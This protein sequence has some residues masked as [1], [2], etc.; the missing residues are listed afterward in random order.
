M[1]RWKVGAKI[2]AGLGVAV[3]I[4]A[5]FL[6]TNAN[7]VHPTQGHCI[8]FRDKLVCPDSYCEAGFE[9]FTCDTTGKQCYCKTILMQSQENRFCEVAAG[10]GM[11]FE[12]DYSNPSNRPI[13]AF[14][15]YGGMWQAIIDRLVWLVKNETNV[16]EF[17][18]EDYGVK[19]ADDELPMDRIVFTPADSQV[20]EFNLKGY[21]SSNF[22]TL[23]ARA[24][25]EFQIGAEEGDETPMPTIQG[26]NTWE[27]GFL[28]EAPKNSTS[29]FV[30]TTIF[31]IIAPN[32]NRQLCSVWPPIE[33]GGLPFYQKLTPAGFNNLDS[34][35]A[36]NIACVNGLSFLSTL[37]LP[38][39]EK[40]G[41]F[42]WLDYIKTPALNTSRNCTPVEIKKVFFGLFENKEPTP[43]MSILAGNLLVAAGETRTAHE[44]TPKNFLMGQL[45]G[46]GDSKESRK[47]KIDKIREGYCKGLCIGDQSKDY[48]ECLNCSPGSVLD[49]LEE[50][51]DS[52]YTQA[53]YSLL[54]TVTKDANDPKSCGGINPSFGYSDARVSR[55]IQVASPSVEYRGGSMT[56]AE[57]NDRLPNSLINIC[58][59]GNQDA[60][61]GH[62]ERLRCKARAL[63]CYE[64]SLQP[65]LKT[66]DICKV[67]N[68]N[69]A[70]TKWAFCP[71]AITQAQ[72][73][74][75]LQDKSWI[76]KILDIPSRQLRD[77]AI[78]I[79]ENFRDIGNILVVCGFIVIIFS[80]LTGIG[81]TNYQI[82]KA[83]PRIIV[84]VILINVS[85]TVMKLALDVASIIGSGI[86]EIFRSAIQETAKNAQVKFTDVIG[87]ILAGTAGGLLLA[88]G[89][90]AFMIPLLIGALI[91]LVS[92]LLTIALRQVL[93]VVLAIISPVAI[94]SL[95]LPDNK[96]FNRWLSA[97]FGLAFIY[98]LMRLLESGG[99][100]VK[101]IILSDARSYGSPT[102]LVALTL[103]HLSI[104]M[105]PTVIKGVLR[106][107]SSIGAR[108]NDFIS[109]FGQ[110]A[111]DHHQQSYLGQRLKHRRAQKLSHLFSGNIR[112]GR[113]SWLS[114]NVFG[115]VSQSNW[116]N[117]LT[118]GAGKASIRRATGS[119]QQQQNQ[120]RQL[121]GN[122]V[123][124]LNAL[125]K[126]GGTAGSGYASLS[127]DQQARYKLVMS[128]GGSREAILRNLTLIAPTIMAASGVFNIETYRQ[129][130]VQ[131]R[132]LGA[133]N[134]ELVFSIVGGLRVG[135]KKGDSE[136]VGLMQ[137][138]LKAPG[139]RNLAPSSAVTNAMSVLKGSNPNFVHDLM[140]QIDGGVDLQNYS[141]GDP[142]SDARIKRL[143]E[144]KIS[145]RDLASAIIL[146][147]ASSASAD[148]KWI[149]SRLTTMCRQ[150]D[151]S[152]GAGTGQKVGDD[153]KL[154]AVSQQHRDL[155]NQIL[156]L[157]E[158]ASAELPT[159]LALKIDQIAADGT[160]SQKAL[161]E[162][163]S[164]ELLG[165]IINEAKKFLPEGWTEDRD[166]FRILPRGVIEKEV[167]AAVLKADA[168]GLYSEMFNLSRE[169][170]QKLGLTTDSIALP[171]VRRLINNSVKE[172]QKI[173]EIRPTIRNKELG[174]WMSTETLVRLGIAWKHIPVAEQKVIRK[175]VEK[176]IS[177]IIGVQ[178]VGAGETIEDAFAKIGVK[179]ED[180]K[181]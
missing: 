24:S 168:G 156:V 86:P 162:I 123:M 42:N 11:L 39:S 13:T 133:T 16:K 144:M 71:I 18:L 131:A 118:S 139:G 90:L 59:D 54:S 150:L 125:L 157:H 26:D 132:S 153:G 56:E 21:F 126:D 80:Q 69:A 14:Y 5:S 46:E 152:V 146:L 167:E 20:K 112:S 49:L 102:R 85:M 35:E 36:E 164:K 75:Q 78:S 10:S 74:D 91:G 100:L 50:K 34:F 2:I 181:R 136:I 15:L 104:F 130:L 4:V 108:F 43:D 138:F 76:K 65:D 97:F 137:A 107:S 68:Q 120:I 148:V 12:R 170:N 110:K 172:A 176:A 1:N 77:N 129:T 27:M 64:D 159:K 72:M 6:Q 94:A 171:V 31:S 175:D 165:S 128:S 158:A 60:K 83:L 40:G 96:W 106:S 25:D 173:R 114:R 58:Q 166:Q 53:L 55:L 117:V 84:V 127:A 8:E 19:L 32:N 149:E 143:I 48:P 124:L 105:M 89:G 37:I 29:A 177:S 3:I 70:T 145:K 28:V 99:E 17:S 61:E 140:N 174:E 115:R 9:N 135:L 33:K 45:F 63:T 82:K 38:Y 103:P 134:N 30:H 113:G 116:F 151:F 161:D 142:A 47:T 44:I 87:G 51:Y 7:A 92:F 22:L 178:A 67:L 52:S 169:G 119:D 179:V 88:L 154:M 23:I 101:N 111:K 122:D 62:N 163:Y 93:I 95:L 81:L 109:S 79:W 66:G 121:V 98:P 160:T 147:E 41:A 180:V 73:A 57:L 141:T 155:L